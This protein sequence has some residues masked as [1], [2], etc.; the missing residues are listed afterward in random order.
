MQGTSTTNGTSAASL[1]ETE[2]DV[3][4]FTTL[5][6]ALCARMAMDGGQDLVE[7]GKIVVGECEVRY[8][9]GESHGETAWLYDHEI[10]VA[11]VDNGAF[12][13]VDDQVKFIPKMTKA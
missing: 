7:L 1:R 6:F 9:I 12:V 5:A 13:A 11:V 3:M 2:G 8:L 10:S 4:D